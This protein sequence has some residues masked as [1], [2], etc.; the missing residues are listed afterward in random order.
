MAAVTGTVVIPK[1][2]NSTRG[3]WRN[4][5]AADG[6]NASARSGEARGEAAGDWDAERGHWRNLTHAGQRTGTDGCNASA[7][8]GEARGEAAG[9]W[10]AARGHWR[11]Y[12]AEANALVSGSKPSKPRHA[13]A[14]CS[15]CSRFMPVSR[16]DS[17][18]RGGQPKR[19]QVS[20]RC[21]DDIL[22]CCHA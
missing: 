7:R 19:Y 22:A 21:G 10:D 20:D 9:D 16:K 3:H 12:S 8:S 4:L 2:P 11:Y 18:V 13:D 14:Q 17:L 1:P 5:N 6:G 15:K